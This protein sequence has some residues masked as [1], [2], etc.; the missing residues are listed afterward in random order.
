MSD[1][2]K[3]PTVEQPEIIR[4]HDDDIRTGIQFEMEAA[5]AQARLQTITDAAR[6]FAEQMRAK[7]GV[8]SDYQMTDWL[9]G[10]VMVKRE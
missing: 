10:F 3:T 5:R 9:T 8:G 7:Y 1:N 2:L 6:L 4:L